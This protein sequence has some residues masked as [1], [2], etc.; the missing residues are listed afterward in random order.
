MDLHRAIRR[1]IDPTDPSDQKL[2][3]YVKHHGGNVCWEFEIAKD[4]MIEVV[5]VSLH[6]MRD[7]LRF[8]SAHIRSMTP[9]GQSPMRG[10]SDVEILLSRC[11]PHGEDG[12]TVTI[13]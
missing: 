4:A 13:R 11:S 6:K 9:L 1:R 7:V 5:G 2:R 10:F 12:F 3:Q 8:D